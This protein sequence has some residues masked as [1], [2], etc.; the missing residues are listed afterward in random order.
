MNQAIKVEI[1][2]DI[3]C[4]FCY[5]G[6]RHFEMA[7]NDFT[8]KGQ[9]SVIMKSFQLDPEAESNGTPIDEYLGR[10]K[11]W[12]LAQVQEM[13]GQLTET[14]RKAGLDMRFDIAVAANTFDA[15]RLLKWAAS[16]GLQAEASK[17]LFEA[18]FTQG[19]DIGNRQ[20]LVDLARQIGLERHKA[21]DLLQ[22][23]TFANEVAND[24]AEARQLGLRGVPFFL[25]NRKYGISGAQPP[26]TFTQAL[27]K[28]RDEVAAQ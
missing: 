17:L 21:D 24:I 25:F 23:R 12:S 7:L 2:S 1:W 19:K 15:H 26:E 28:L 9:V 5:I 14:A 4:P 3:V 16:E 13:H 18:H 10:T 6:K 8:G 11:G 20:T 22:N 27:H